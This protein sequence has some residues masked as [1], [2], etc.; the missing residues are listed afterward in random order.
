MGGLVFAGLVMGIGFFG[1]LALEALGKR[2]ER[3]NKY[4]NGG[5]L[6]S[7]YVLKHAL[8]IKANEAYASNRNEADLLFWVN[9]EYSDIYF[10]RN[11]IDIYSECCDN[12]DQYIERVPRVKSLKEVDRRAKKAGYYF[13]PTLNSYDLNNKARGGITDH[14]LYISKIRALEAKDKEIKTYA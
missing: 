2:I 7:G 13:E 11:G 5:A 12:K 8:D 4:K 9:R 3:H 14:N 6:A 10:Q 1:Y